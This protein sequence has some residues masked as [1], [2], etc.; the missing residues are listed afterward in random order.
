MFC[1]NCGKELAQGTAFCT[2]CGKKIEPGVASS[3]PEPSEQPTTIQDLSEQPTTL[4]NTPPQLIDPALAEAFAYHDE[5]GRT[6]AQLQQT[7]RQQMPPGQVMPSP[8]YSEQ[9][10]SV[11]RKTWPIVAAILGAGALVGVFIGG[12]FLFMNQQGASSAESTQE[13]ETS[14]V[15][16]KNDDD[17]LDE[18]KNESNE[19]TSEENSTSSSDE[20]KTAK[21]DSSTNEPDAST[22]LEAAAG[23]TTNSA[24]TSVL[25]ARS[26]G[27]YFF[28]D[29][30][31]S[32]LSRSDLEM[33]SDYELY[34]ARNELLAR[35]GFTFEPGKTDKSNKIYKYL[36]SKSWYHPTYNYDQWCAMGGE[37]GILTSI[38]YDNFML[39]R[40]I[41]NERLSSWRP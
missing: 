34:I 25:G 30:G 18:K 4:Q 21:T 7:Q 32:R 37:A 41:E 20:D 28:I 22:N 23:I 5:F 15:I 13:E 11:K 10:Q 8:Q 6:Q 3:A 39:I 31:A 27:G 16:I 35:H 2:N 12:A 38:E 26:S 29:P 33:L 1:T 19:T 14:K 24:H 40:T 9:P 17:S 36:S